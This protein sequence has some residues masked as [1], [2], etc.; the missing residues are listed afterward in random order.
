[1]A[2]QRCM[3]TAL[4]AIVLTGCVC[5][6]AVAQTGD[7][8]EESTAPRVPLHMRMNRVI[9]EVDLDTRGTRALDWWSRT[10]EVPLLINWRWM[11]LEG[12]D[13]DMPVALSL[14]GVP[15][16]DVLRLILAQVFPDTP[17]VVEISPHYVQVMTITQANRHPV[18][19]IY[20]VQGMLHTIPSFTD[21]PV[22][23]LRR[24]LSNTNSGGGGG[25]TGVAKASGDLFGEGAFKRERP[26]TMQERGEEL[27]ELI[28]NLIAPNIW[29]AYGGQYASIRYFRGKLIVHAPH[30]VH[31]QIGGRVGASGRDPK[32]ALSSAPRRPAARYPAYQRRAAGTRTYS[33]GRRG[34]AGVQPFDDVPVSRVGD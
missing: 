16:R 9:N 32:A 17:T 29:Q 21:T 24:A 1:M 11:E 28:R 2:K 33:T 34:I 14:R 31:M 7:A 12:F 13:A 4:F 23:D 15:A 10:T 22:F 19:R 8:G 26:R 3:F 6:V 25:A 5:G 30:Y 20:D 18:L 27:A